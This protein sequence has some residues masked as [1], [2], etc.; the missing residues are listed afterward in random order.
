MQIENDIEKYLVKQ[1]KRIGAL[2]YKFTSPGNRG[3]PDRL[4]LYQ[5]N[6]FFVELKRPGGKPR[7]DQ[8]KTIEKF[9]E[10][11]ILVLVI[12]SKQQVDDLL[13]MMEKGI[14]RCMPVTPS[15]RSD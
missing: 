10:Q 5:G 7:K 6:V 12:D 2:C 9:N 15:K 14:A 3:V 4:I 13:Y 1:V 11:L 8:L